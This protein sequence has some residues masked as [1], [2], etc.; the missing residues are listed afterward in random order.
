M[1]IKKRSIGGRATK[2]KKPRKISGKKVPGKKKGKK[3]PGKKK[4]IPILSFRKK[5][6]RLRKG[7]AQ[8]KKGSYY[9]KSISSASMY[10]NNRGKKRVS[11]HM[12]V[13]EDTGGDKT[14]WSKKQNNEYVG[15]TG[16]RPVKL[17]NIKTADRIYKSI[18]IP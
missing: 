18:P 5:H 8:T 15:T 17:R 1:P 13:T 12:D 14:Y 3:V 10:S 9:S 7:P 11:Q 2:K 4:G 6:Q 16:R